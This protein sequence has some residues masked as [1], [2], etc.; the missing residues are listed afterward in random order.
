MEELLNE[1]YAR[2]IQLVSSIITYIEIIAYPLKLKEYNL[3]A[4]YRDYFTN[5]ENISLYPLNFFIADETANLR[6]KYNLKMPDAIQIATAKQCG[7]DFIITNDKD[8]EKVKG[9]KVTLLDDLH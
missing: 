8:W 4:K 6:A 9:L 1:A 5:S 2:Q 3:A 7:A